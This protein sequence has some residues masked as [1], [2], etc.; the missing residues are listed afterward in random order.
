MRSLRLV[1][2]S[3]RTRQR[4]DVG[5]PKVSQNRFCHYGKETSEEK[6]V[7]IYLSLDRGLFIIVSN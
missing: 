5:Q 1:Q 3:E 4:V 7:F 6:N 2:G